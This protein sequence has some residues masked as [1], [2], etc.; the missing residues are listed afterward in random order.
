MEPLNFTTTFLVDQSPRQVFNAVNN[1]QNWW[2]GG[3]TDST[4][5]LNAEFT[6]S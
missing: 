3:I 5:E 2:L 1:P 4:T 6:Y